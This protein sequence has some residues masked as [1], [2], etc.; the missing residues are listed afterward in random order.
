[1][2]ENPR[3]QDSTCDLSCTS[4]NQQTKMI[5]G[6]MHTFWYK[7]LSKNYKMTSCGKG[8]NLIK[9]TAQAQRRIFPKSQYWL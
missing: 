6:S 1:M 8:K 4:F 2:R 5:P 3:S 7:P 9:I